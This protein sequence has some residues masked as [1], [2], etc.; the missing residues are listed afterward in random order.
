MNEKGLR[1]ISIDLLRGLVMIIMALDHAR[2]F[3]HADFFKGNDPLDF[4][5]T[6]VPLFLTRWI[7]HFCAPVFVFLAG[8]SAFFSG[9][10]KTKKQ[11]ALFLF[12][13]GL[14]LM[15][16][17]IT[18]VNFGWMFDFTFRVI[19]IQVIWAI[20]LSMVFMSAFIFLPVSVVFFTG[21]ALV[22]GHNLFDNLRVENNTTLNFLWSLAH[23][24]EQFKPTEY[25]TII[26][27]YPFVPWLGLMM[28]GYGF[29]KFYSSKNKELLKSK[30]PALAVAGLFCLLIFFLLR[31][32]NFYGDAHY[33]KMQK[34][35]IFTVLSFFDCTKYPP[36]LLY[37][38]M[39]IGPSLLFLAISEKVKGK[40]PEIISIYGR[41]PLFYYVIHIYL[42]HIIAGILFFATG[43][44]MSEIDFSE[45]LPQAPK[46]FGF[47]LLTV[48]FVWIICVVALYFPCKW[49]SDY[50][51]T[52]SQWWLSYL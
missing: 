49:F 45:A 39:T 29:G 37:L 7:T 50:K 20:G 11:L 15:I 43:H 1:I 4:A 25:F 17:E 52:H 13:R 24:P 28:T 21:L 19:F 33:W 10:K 23:Q 31:S 35:G 46:N 47:S 8:A 26:V 34:T 6:S 44:S 36:S 18:V 16:L 2:D 38:L 27:A 32:G 42:L 41:V 22:F 40:I 3:L 12:T 30:V 51:R 48:Y 14:W 9:K 5:T